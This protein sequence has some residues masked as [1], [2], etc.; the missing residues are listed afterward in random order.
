MKK[1]F[2]MVSFFISTLGLVSAVSGILPASWFPAFAVCSFV[3]GC[4]G[5]FINVPL[6]A[7]TQETIA[8]EML[9]KVFP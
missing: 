1:R 6:M 2:L 5:T 7:Y 3:M 4:T 8:P 9:G